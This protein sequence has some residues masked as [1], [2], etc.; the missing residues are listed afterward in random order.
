MSDGDATAV[1]HVD[2]GM[3]NVCHC[4]LISKQS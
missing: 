2:D 4:H 3:F 1:L